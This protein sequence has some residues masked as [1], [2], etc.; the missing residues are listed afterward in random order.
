MMIGSEEGR[1]RSRRQ[2]AFVLAIKL[3]IMA[4]GRRLLIRQSLFTVYSPILNGCYIWPSVMAFSMFDRS[5]VS[6]TNIF[7]FLQFFFFHQDYC[8]SRMYFISSVLLYTFT[9]LLTEGI[10][11]WF[12]NMSLQDVDAHDSP[13][14]PLFL[15]LQVTFD[16][17]PSL[18][19]L[20]CHPHVTSFKILYPSTT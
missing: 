11:L 17:L 10:I 8:S 19:S 5:S 6:S 9:C 1:Y 2:G 13:Q 20:F 16:H 15:L 14:L 7:L 12:I 3:Q 4:D 18:L